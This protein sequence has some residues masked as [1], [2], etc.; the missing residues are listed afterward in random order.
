MKTEFPDEIDTT[1]RHIVCMRA[2]KIA[3]MMPPHG[4]MTKQDAL[5]LA[6]WLVMLADPIGEQFE[7]TL[8][9]IANA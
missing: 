4:E 8:S 3:I 5:T 7:R 9:A 2:D 1:N 6:A